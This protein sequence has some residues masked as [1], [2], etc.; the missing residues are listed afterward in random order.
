MCSCTYSFIHPYLHGQLCACIGAWLLACMYLGMSIRMHISMKVYSWVYGW[1]KCIRVSMYVHTWV[2]AC[3]H[4]KSNAD[5]SWNFSRIDLVRGDS[6]VRRMDADFSRALVKPLRRQSLCVSMRVCICAVCF[7]VI[8]YP[9]MHAVVYE[10]NVTQVINV[11]PCLRSISIASNQLQV[12][13]I[14]V[15]K[16]NSRHQVHEW[17]DKQWHESNQSNHCNWILSWW[18]LFGQGCMRGFGALLRLAHTKYQVRK[19]ASYFQVWKQW[20]GDLCN[21]KEHDSEAMSIGDPS[22]ALRCQVWSG[23][24]C[25]LLPTQTYYKCWPFVDIGLFGELGI[26]GDTHLP[27]G[28]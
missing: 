6:R 26:E 1:F 8:I 22:R 28:R 3:A 20:N 5:T 16:T 4:I 18:L 24:W 11:M 12:H 15:T 23:R 17:N 2:Y 21:F 7:N 27:F 14:T 25:E 13:A 10:S 19:R 9:F